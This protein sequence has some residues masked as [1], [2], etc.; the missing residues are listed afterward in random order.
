M[1]VLP[2]NIDERKIDENW[3]KYRGKFQEMI[4]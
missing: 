4:K 3:Y 1:K 2:K